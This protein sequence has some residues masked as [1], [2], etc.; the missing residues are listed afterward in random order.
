MVSKLKL[1]EDNTDSNS[2]DSRTEDAS[3]TETLLC[4]LE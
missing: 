4:D 3:C 1:T 2:T